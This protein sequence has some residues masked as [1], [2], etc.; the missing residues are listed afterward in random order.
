MMNEVFLLSVET[1]DLGPV[2][3]AANTFVVK[4]A[5]QIFRGGSPV[6]P[7]LWLLVRADKPDVICSHPS[8]SG[9][10][11]CAYQFTRSHFRPRRNA[12]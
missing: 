5:Q 11:K 2:N 9:R 12:H 10:M 6:L 8:T 7:K 4:S 3:F 1:F